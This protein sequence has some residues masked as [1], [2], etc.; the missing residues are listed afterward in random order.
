MPAFSES[1]PTA[2]IYKHYWKAL[3]LVINQHENN[4]DRKEHELRFENI[5]ILSANDCGLNG[6]ASDEKGDC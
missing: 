2:E 4:F 1:I 6:N 5:F 3:P